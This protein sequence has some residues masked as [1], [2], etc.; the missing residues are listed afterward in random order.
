M[1]LVALSVLIGS[2]ACWLPSFSFPSLPSLPSLSSFPGFSSSPPAATNGPMDQLT[3]RL[4]PFLC[5]KWS[6]VCGNALATQL[7]LLLNRPPA[8]LAQLADELKNPA[9]QTIATAF[10][11]AAM[12]GLSNLADFSAPTPS[13][14][15]FNLRDAITIANSGNQTNY[16]RMVQDLINTVSNPSLSS[17]N[18]TSSFSSFASY[19]SFI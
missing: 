11:N 12:T 16:Q 6:N 7:T 4:S 8:E 15:A 5:L 13:T 18:S 2:A 10:D 14:S 19:G 9:Y 1:Q 3:S 17:S